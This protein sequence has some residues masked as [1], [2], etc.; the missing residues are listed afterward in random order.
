MALMKIP[1]PAPQP[2]PLPRV[3]LTAAIAPGCRQRNRRRDHRNDPHCHRQ[4][5]IFAAIIRNSMQVPLVRP[6]RERVLQSFSGYARGVHIP[7]LWMT[8]QIAR[9]H[10]DYLV[11]IS[12]V[13]QTNK[14]CLLRCAHSYQSINYARDIVRAF[15]R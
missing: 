3:S 14:R 2:P 10:S 8:A 5:A 4:L 7:F 13:V 12:S 9:D 6:T 11:K 15:F 1:E